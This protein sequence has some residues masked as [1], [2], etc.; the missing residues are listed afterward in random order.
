[1]TENTNTSTPATTAPVLTERAQQIVTADVTRAVKG[2]L[3]YRE[4]VAEMNVTT[5]TVPAHVAVFRGAYR[6][7]TEKAVEKAE[8]A[9]V[10]AREQHAAGRA[11]EVTVLAAIEARDVAV[12]HASGTAVKAYANVIRMG[13]KH[14]AVKAEGTES[15]PS[16]EVTEEE[17][18][19]EGTSTPDYMADI[20]GR[21]DVAVTAGL[22]A[23]D[24]LA[25]VQ[26]H[27]AA[28]LS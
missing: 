20:M 9:L 12:S 3:A 11:E 25:A 22:D 6:V 19:E 8:R 13:L 5:E 24:I 28:L 15:V 26:A 17:S 18:T 23:G 7:H 2:R 10:I 14:W 16:E 27:V 1:M 21:I 4:Y